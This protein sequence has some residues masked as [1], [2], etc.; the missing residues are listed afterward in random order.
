MQATISTE[1]L[2]KLFRATPEQM[3][4]IE[5]ILGGQWPG[6]G[7]GAAQ[8][9]SGH[10]GGDAEATLM[11]IEQK[12]DAVQLAVASGVAPESLAMTAER[13]DRNSGAALPRGPAAA[14]EIRQEST[15]RRQ[16]RHDRTEISRWRMRFNG[17]EV[18]MP[19]SVGTELLVHLIRNQGKDFSAATLAEAVRKSG[20]GSG[21][22]GDVQEI[23]RGQDGD[24]QNNEDLRGRIGDVDER[25]VVWDEREIAG[26]LS[27]IKALSA[28]I[29]DHEEAG[30]DSS[31]GCRVLKEKLEEQ[32]DLMRANAKQVN[33][34]WVPKEYRKGTFGK[35]ADLI[36][37]HIRGV[38]DDFLRENCRPLFDHLHD[39]ET[40]SYG[41]NN[42]YKPSPRIEWEIQLKEEQNR[43]VYFRKGT[44]SSAF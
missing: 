27:K 35:K 12:V 10:G 21:H 28:E 39:R 29:T 40:L 31:E 26:C 34:K 2:T 17:Q 6:G 25:D 43:K 33:G 42:C 38:L 9:V 37:K 30:D 3:S 41:V 18:L 32:Q 19:E 4:A 7:G 36:R 22:G 44:S 15:R 5:L 14:Y 1:L 16:G 13:F 11:R 20:P 23:L 8:D 24:G